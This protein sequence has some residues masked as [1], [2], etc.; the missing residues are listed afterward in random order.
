MEVHGY[1]QSGAIDATIDGQRVTVP[2]AGGNRHRQLIAEWEAEGNTIP[3]YVPPP[4]PEPD[5]ETILREAMF[6]DFV[7]RSAKN[8]STPK[9]I[10]D[11]ALAL[12]A[13]R[14]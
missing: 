12:K 7:E 13:Q 4:A 10:K 14:K 6:E 3:A 5:P 11:A 8:A 1:T 9:A 2:D